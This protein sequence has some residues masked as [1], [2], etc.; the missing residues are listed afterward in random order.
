MFVRVVVFVKM[1][2]AYWCNHCLSTNPTPIPPPALPPTLN[3]ETV[4]KAL[5]PQLLRCES[6]S[7][8]KRERRFCPAPTNTP[9]TPNR[10]QTSRLF[11][12]FHCRLSAGHSKEKML[13]KTDL[14][15]N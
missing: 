3:K 1:V 15:R 13:L 11:L 4:S 8:E 5:L 10:R 6:L 9:D 12:S 2:K 14:M 7:H